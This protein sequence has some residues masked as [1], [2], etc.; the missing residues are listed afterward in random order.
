MGQKR[1]KLELNK[2]V[3]EPTKLCISNSLVSNNVAAIEER[4]TNK[5]NENVSSLNLQNH[6]KKGLNTYASTSKS[7]VPASIQSNTTCKPS[8]FQLYL[9]TILKKLQTKD[10]SDFFATPVTDEIAPL[11]ST[12]ISHPMDFST[13]KRKINQNLYKTIESFQNDVKLICENAML[14]NAPYTVYY[15]KAERL[16]RHAE[17][18]IFTKKALIKLA[19]RYRGLNAAIEYELK[20]KSN[21]GVLSAECAD[22]NIAIESVETHRKLI[23]SQHDCD[24]AEDTTMD[25]SPIQ[26]STCIENLQCSCLNTLKPADKENTELS[27]SETTNKEDLTAEQILAHVDKAAKKLTNRVKYK[28]SHL[29]ILRP[30]NDGTTTLK[31]ISEVKEKP[32]TLGS[33]VGPLSDGLFD[34]PPYKEPEENLVNL[35]DSVPTEPF[36]SF[37]PS[38]DSSYATLSQEETRT[39]IEAF[40]D[41]DVCFQY[42]HSILSFSDGNDL[43]MNMADRIIKTLTDKQGKELEELALEFNIDEENLEENENESKDEGETE[44]ET[45]YE[46]EAI[47]ISSDDDEPQV[48]SSQFISNPLNEHQPINM[49]PSTS[50]VQPISLS[51]DEMELTELVNDETTIL[52]DSQD[53]E[54]STRPDCMLLEDI[55]RDLEIGN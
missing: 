31:I 37:L 45:I 24:M 14:Y 48:L 29:S 1:S 36:S 12:V 15:K 49:Q 17:Q 47:D 13:M 7:S 23:E 8:D 44:K 27:K 19:R 9:G 10:D 50:C 18:K 34:L 39:L 54:T 55:I 11:Y 3:R 6:L 53:H 38:W 32:V 26:S 25:I 52:S 28:G 22:K 16:W 21:G 43:A 51:N 41:D 5:E 30:K 33:L 4:I 46:I 2:V 40:G 42:T 35:I 20:N